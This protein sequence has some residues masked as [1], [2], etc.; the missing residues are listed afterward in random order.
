[1]TLQR[2]NGCADWWNCHYKAKG[3]QYSVFSSSIDKAIKDMCEELERDGV[4][5]TAI[6]T[7]I[8]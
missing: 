2:V 7:N 4:Y 1:M 3:K 8:V 5:L 6:K